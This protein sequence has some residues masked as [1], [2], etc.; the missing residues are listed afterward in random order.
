MGLASGE[1]GEGLVFQRAN[2]RVTILPQRSPKFIE[3]IFGIFLKGSRV[4]NGT[5][6][7]VGMRA[8]N[9]EPEGERTMGGR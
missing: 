2:S 7:E 9:S 1:L 6:Y 3:W 5:K 4:V 8:K